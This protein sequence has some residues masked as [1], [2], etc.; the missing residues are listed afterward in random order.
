MLIDTTKASTTSKRG[1]RY[2]QLFSLPNGRVRVFAL[3]SKSNVH[4]TLVLIFKR[5][6]VPTTMIMDS[7]K[8]QTLR[9]IE[10]VQAGWLPC[11]TNRSLVSLGKYL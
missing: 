3:P 5:E 11:K 8:E 10:K 6:G 7:S 2:S 9:Q 1:N 4:D